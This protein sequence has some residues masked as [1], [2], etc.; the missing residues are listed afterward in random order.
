MGLFEKEGQV[1]WDLVMSSLDPTVPVITE[2]KRGPNLEPTQQD[3]MIKIP[4][5]YKTEAYVKDS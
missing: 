1:Q 2:P 5:E 4:D 3:H